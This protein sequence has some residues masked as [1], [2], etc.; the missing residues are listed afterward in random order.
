L[1]SVFER[2][3]RLEG[4]MGDMGKM[5]GWEFGE[6]DIALCMVVQR[7]EREKEG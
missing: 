5:G 2:C 1:E 6:G 3:E 4:K 7:W